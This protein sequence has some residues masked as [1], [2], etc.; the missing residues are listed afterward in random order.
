LLPEITETMT[1][2]VILSSSCVESGNFREKMELCL[3][4]S[5]KRT[6]PERKLRGLLWFLLEPEERF[7]TVVNIVKT[8][9]LMLFK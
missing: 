3:W 5:D 4:R 2:R 9:V 1:D 8:D 6:K 7:G